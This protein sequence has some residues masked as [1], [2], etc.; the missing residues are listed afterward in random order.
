MA[1]CL[2]D[3]LKLLFQLISSC[4]VR[5]SRILDG[6]LLACLMIAMIISVDFELLGEI[7]PHNL[8]AGGAEIQVTEENKV[9]GPQH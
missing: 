7:K 1:D 6:R 4:W 5:Q 9:G 3:S 8:K 2:L